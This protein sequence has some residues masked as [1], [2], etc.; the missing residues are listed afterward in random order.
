MPCAAEHTKM[1]LYFLLGPAWHG[2][3]EVCTR[4]MSKNRL[5]HSLVTWGHAAMHQ[6]LGWVLVTGKYKLW[7]LL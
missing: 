6:T 7:S 1:D 2:A 3:Q 5:A 4:Y